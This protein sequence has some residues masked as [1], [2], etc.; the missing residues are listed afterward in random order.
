[1]KMVFSETAQ[2]E[3]GD[4]SG[5]VGRFGD[6]CILVFTIHLGKGSACSLLT[7]ERGPTKPCDHSPWVYTGKFINLLEPWRNKRLSRIGK[8]SMCLQNLAVSTES[9]HLCRL[10]SGFDRQ[11]AGKLEKVAD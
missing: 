1:M 10:V 8:F 4:C 3:L 2:I 11:A 7:Q 5:H 9:C 6:C